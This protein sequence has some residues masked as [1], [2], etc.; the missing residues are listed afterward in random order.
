MSEMSFLA[1]FVADDVSPL[2]AA[3]IVSG[4]QDAAEV[5]Q[6]ARAQAERA[7]LAE[8]RAAA[9]AFA[10]KQHGN[11]LAELTRARQSA[12]T[13]EDEFRDAEARFQKAQAKLTRAQDNVRFF[14]ERAAQVQEVA[15]RSAPSNDPLLQAQRR[16]HAAFVE[17]TRHRLREAALGREPMARR[18]FATGLAVRSDTVTCPQCAELGATAEESFMIHHMDADGNLA[19]AVTEEE[20]RMRGEPGREITRVVYQ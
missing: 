15:Q 11:P 17:A 19:A 6:E 4:R 5:R 2:E 14:A 8:D 20:R 18:P 1:G 13:A 12:M 16:A 3:Q 9:M 10:E 7:A